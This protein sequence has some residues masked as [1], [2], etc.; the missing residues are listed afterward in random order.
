MEY[1]RHFQDRKMVAPIRELNTP[2]TAFTALTLDTNHDGDRSISGY[3]APKGLSL[4]RRSS[5]NH[6]L[7]YGC[8]RL[9][10]GLSS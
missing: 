7:H 1:S 6:R 10:K 3:K 8:H 9:W 5:S 4:Y 2:L